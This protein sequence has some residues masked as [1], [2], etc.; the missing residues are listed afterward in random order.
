MTLILQDIV[1]LWKLEFLKKI[2]HVFY[3]ITRAFL[4]KSPVNSKS[5]QWLIATQDWVPPVRLLED[6]NVSSGDTLEILQP[7][8]KPLERKSRAS[9][10][11]FQRRSWTCWVWSVLWCP[12]AG[13][14]NDPTPSSAWHVQWCLPQHC[15]W[16]LTGTR[17]PAAKNIT[18]LGTELTTS[19]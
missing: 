3:E 13:W 5:N 15:F 7:C 9:V 11:T 16:S 12:Y 14:P 18:S 10:L 19:C 2:P 6:S 8:N 1:C 4:R 17:S